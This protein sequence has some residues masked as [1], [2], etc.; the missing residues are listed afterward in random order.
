[1]GQFGQD[2]PLF[3]VYCASPLS[4]LRSSRGT[5]PPPVCASQPSGMASMLPTAMK[6]LVKNVTRLVLKTNMSIKSAGLIYPIDWST[7]LSHYYLHRAKMLQKPWRSLVGSPWRLRPTS[8]RTERDA[9]CHAR[10]WP[11]C[12]LTQEE[13]KTDSLSTKHLK[14][15]LIFF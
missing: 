14:T 8:Q 4:D 2:W 10:T 15:I 3:Q 7:Y 13:R 9:T 12:T 11:N 6:I 1:M 5:S